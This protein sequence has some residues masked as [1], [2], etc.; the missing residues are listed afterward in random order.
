MAAVV[1][2]AKQ[3]LRVPTLLLRVLRALQPRVADVAVTGV[4]DA[5]AQAEVV[6]LQALRLAQ[7]LP[8]TPSTWMPPI[9]PHSISPLDANRVI[10][11]AAL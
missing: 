9:R 5:E 3:A 2:L 11:A 6:E 8:A 4:V 10:P 7:P 1:N